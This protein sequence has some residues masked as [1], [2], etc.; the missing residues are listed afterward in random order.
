MTRLVDAEDP[1]FR[2]MLRVATGL[3]DLRELVVFT[4]GAVTGLLVT[5]P[6][7]SAH[8]PTED[9]DLIIQITTLA[10]YH[11]L[12]KRLRALG[13]SECQDQGA[14]LCRWVFEG[15]LVDVMPTS[16]KVLGFRNRWFQLALDRAARVRIPG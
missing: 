6:G 15:T 1:R 10:D 12:G 11:V 7:A 14:P 9:V 5:D 8:R 3:R 2:P 4:G 16:E 13:F